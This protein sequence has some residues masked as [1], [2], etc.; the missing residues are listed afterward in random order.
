MPNWVFNSLTIRGIESDLQR[1]KK[2]AEE[3]DSG[4]AN[5]GVLKL[6]QFVPMPPHLRVKNDVGPF[7]LPSWYTWGCRNWGTKWDLHRA[8]LI[9]DGKNGRPLTYSFG[10]AWSP[11]FVALNE[12]ALQF[13]NLEFELHAEEPMNEDCFFF[14][15][16]ASYELFEHH[17]VYQ[18]S[19]SFSQEYDK[20][21]N[22]FK[23]KVALFRKA[24]EI[25]TNS[26]EKPLA[27]DLASHLSGDESLV[28]EIVE[29]FIKEQLISEIEK[30]S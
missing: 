27:A 15:V 12:I 26:K 2:I 5:D 11:P 4:A 6:N 25:L 13:P 29:L 8:L 18:W 21:A 20:I 24:V 23:D 28:K 1:F 16:K 10:S 22:R 9:N 3:D 14:F 7:K 17:K 19:K 30:A